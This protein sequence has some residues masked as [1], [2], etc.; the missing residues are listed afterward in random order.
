MLSV[1]TILMWAPKT[2]AAASRAS[3]NPE[4]VEAQALQC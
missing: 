2:E 3:I 4:L 1:H